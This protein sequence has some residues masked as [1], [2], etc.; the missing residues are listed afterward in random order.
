MNFLS[1]VKK[2]FFLPML[3]LL[4]NACTNNTVFNE[5]RTL[6]ENGWHKDSACVFVVPVEDTTSTYSVLIDIRNNTDY[7]YQNFWL[8]VNYQNPD[9]TTKHDTIECYLADNEG[10]WLGSGI[11]SLRQMSVLVDSAFVFNQA[12]TYQISI[13]QAMR[14]TTLAGINDIGLE[15]IKNNKK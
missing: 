15:I 2:T 14:D 13:Q 3:C 6:L 10:K 1:I 11:G 4:L 7:K 12:G 9:K 8:F 5:Q